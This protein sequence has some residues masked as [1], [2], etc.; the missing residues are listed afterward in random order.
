MRFLFRSLTGL[1]LAAL[2]IALLAAGGFTMKSAI[3]ARKEAPGRM[4]AQQER[5][6]AANVIALEFGARQPELTAYGEVRTLRELELRAPAAG[7]LLELSPNFVE[8]G[9]VVAGELLARLDPAETQ[10]ARDSAAA[11]TAEAATQLALAERTL[12]IARDDLVAAERQVALRQKALERARSIGERGFGA[13]V[14]IET[15]ELAVSSAEQAVLTKRSAL[16]SA[17]AGLDQA[18]NALRRAEIALSEAE[19]KL[20]ETEIRADF[21]GQLS[22]I[23]TVAGR[24]VSNNEIL[25]T[26]IDPAT[27]E[28]SFRVPTAQF[29]RLT[30]EKGQLLPLQA[31]VTLDLGA[32]H[33]AVP[34]TLERAGA[35]VEEGQAGRLLFARLEAVRGLKAGDFVT[36]TL[37]MPELE[38]VALLPAAAVGPDGTVLRLDADERLRAERVEVVHRQ[39]DDVLIRAAALQ[40]GVEVVA[41]RSPLL[42]EG[43]KLRPLRPG[44]DG[45]GLVPQ[46]PAQVTL[47][48]GHRARLIAAVEGNTR[49]PAE[50]KARMLAT[51]QQ[52]QVPADLV[53]RIESRMGG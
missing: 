27:L 18:R 47:D 45:A 13:T 11:S 37:S 23:D 22:G 43:L 20:A 50:A 30:D 7:T 52:D 39:G 41:E 8:G 4:R 28:V 25:G 2:T 6:F 40:S 48:A 19:R 5:V 15:A 1:F 34:A 38:N 33:I 29:A 10:A 24:L 36:V 9:Q 3:D 14:D 21:A 26:L 44:A 42:G 17:E 12:V 16:S 31:K 53:E 35:A 51:L 49:M 46:K 32:D